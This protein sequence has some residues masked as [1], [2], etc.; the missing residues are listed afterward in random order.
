MNKIKYV[1]TVYQEKSF[2]RAA[3]K[4]F[5]SQ[6][7]ISKTIKQVESEI[8]VPIFD[9]STIPLTLT[10]EGEI[11]IA[12]ARKISHLDEDLR[13]YFS[14]IH[15]LKTGTLTVGGSSF[16]CS[17][18]LPDMLGAFSRK[19][20]NISLRMQEGSVA[21]LRS[22]LEDESID[23]IVETAFKDTDSFLNTYYL[24]S[25]DIVLAVPADFAINDSLKEYQLAYER[26]QD[27]AY[28]ESA[29]PVP[30]ERF[31]SLPFVLLT[32]GNDLLPRS[33]ALC[34]EAKFTPKIAL[35]V[36][37]ILTATNLCAAGLGVTFTRPAVTQCYP[38]SR[39]ICFYRIGGPL[40][41]RKIYL[42]SKSSRHV[43]RAMS[44][45]VQIALKSF[46][47]QQTD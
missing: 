17:F 20:P 6:A 14:D 23:L 44:A 40:A 9:R 41:K 22:G 21:M 5:I 4:L 32:E 27:A 16:F 18:L 39:K 2:T 36:D 45:F 12:Y 26:L 8:G 15:N 10:Q 29:S 7:A 43:N 24:Y 25:E 19:Y 37:Q 35:Q 11:Y 46:P 1:L 47:H 13:G 33:I 31:S 42:A 34:K 30:L 3:E 38:F 28:M